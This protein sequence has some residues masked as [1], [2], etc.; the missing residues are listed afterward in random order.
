[1]GVWRYVGK[2]LNKSYSVYYGRI[3]MGNVLTENEGRAQ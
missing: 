2:C 1:M 3:L